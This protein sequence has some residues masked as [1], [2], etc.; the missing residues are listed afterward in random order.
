MMSHTTT[1]KTQIRNFSDLKKAIETANWGGLKI[2]LRGDEKSD[3]L[4]LF[5]GND[6]INIMKVQGV[7]QFVGDNYFMRSTTIEKATAIINQQ[8]AYNKVMHSD[9]L[10]RY[11]K[12]RESRVNNQ[13]HITL[14]TV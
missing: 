5:V 6:R 11:I 14:R 1:V 3:T 12:V 8:F 2:E 7:Y 10:R 4:T 9:T 13:I